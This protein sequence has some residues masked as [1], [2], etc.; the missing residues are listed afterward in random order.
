MKPL[1]AF[2]RH[3]RVR[4]QVAQELRRFLTEVDGTPMSIARRMGKSQEYCSRVFSDR[5]VP[6]WQFL[7]DLAHSYGYTVEVRIAKAGH[8]TRRPQRSGQ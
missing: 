4:R 7:A 5:F 6:S 2:P 8:R 3:Q 1:D